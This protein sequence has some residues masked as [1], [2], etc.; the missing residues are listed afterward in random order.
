M[1]VNPLNFSTSDV[2]AKLRRASL[3]ASNSGIGPR[4]VLIPISKGN[5]WFAPVFSMGTPQL[6]LSA[7]AIVTVSLASLPPVSDHQSLPTAS[8]SASPLLLPHHPQPPHHHTSFHCDALLG[9]MNLKTV[10][11]SRP[12][13]GPDLFST[14]REEAAIFLEGP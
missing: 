6:P 9:P 11:G 5:P 4:C 7:F 2:C 10:L 14:Q 12:P 1:A 13:I 8:F 3:C